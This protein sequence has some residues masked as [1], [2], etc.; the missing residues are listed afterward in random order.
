[1]EIIVVKMIILP[2]IDAVGFVLNS[3]GEQVG[4]IS[5]SNATQTHKNTYLFL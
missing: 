4:L 1:V 2:L 5:P 3:I